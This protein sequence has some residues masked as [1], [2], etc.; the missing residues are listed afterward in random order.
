MRWLY[1]SISLALILIWL[2]GCSST[3]QR[4]EIPIPTPCKVTMPAPPERCQPADHSRVEWLRCALT[5]YPRRI[6]YE[7]ELEAALKACA[8]P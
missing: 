6:G 2:A 3:P 5:D 4:V 7:A 1:W 8:G